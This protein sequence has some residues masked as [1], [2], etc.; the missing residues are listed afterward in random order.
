MCVS[1]D[2]SVCNSVGDSPAHGFALQ[3]SQ[4]LPVWCTLPGHVFAPASAECTLCSIQKYDG[5]QK[6]CGLPVCFARKMIRGIIA[7][8]FRDLL[9][10]DLAQWRYLLEKKC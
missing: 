8:G 5:C 1:S 9:S 4:H 10:F 2:P 6:E 3:P 7:L